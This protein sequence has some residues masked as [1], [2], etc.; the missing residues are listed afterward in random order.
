VGHVLQHDARVHV[1]GLEHEQEVLQ[2]H[3]QVDQVHEPQQPEQHLQEHGRVQQLRLVEDAVE[4]AAGGVGAP[5]GLA[6][7]V[8]L[9]AEDGVGQDHEARQGAVGLGS[10]GW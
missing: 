1:R 4:L 6:S 9:L 3:L 10:H 8:G 5:T 2:A 7:R